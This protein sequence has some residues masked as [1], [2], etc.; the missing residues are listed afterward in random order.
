ML[1]IR[2]IALA[3]TALL[4]MLACLP[5]PAPDL[6]RPCKSNAYSV[7]EQ[8]HAQVWACILNGLV[9]LYINVWFAHWLGDSLACSSILTMH[10]EVALEKLGSNLWEGIQA[11]ALPQSSSSHVLR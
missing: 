3:A 1:T 5:R 4:A 11:K 7:P 8:A 9:L 6:M 2:Q 10:L